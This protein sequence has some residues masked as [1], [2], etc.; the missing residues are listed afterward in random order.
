MVL[1]DTINDAGGVLILRCGLY[2]Y[3][4]VLTN[5]VFLTCSSGLARLCTIPV[6]KRKCICVHRSKRAYLLYRY[7]IQCLIWFFKLVFIS[8][9][10]V[11]RHLEFYKQYFGLMGCSLEATGVKIVYY[12]DVSTVPSVC[13]KVTCSCVKYNTQLRKADMSFGVGKRK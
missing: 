5:S 2:W 7:I 9:R 1:I 3:S 10:A 8:S 12:I 4:F 13:G 6:A 11:E